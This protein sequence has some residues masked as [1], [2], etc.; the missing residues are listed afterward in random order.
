MTCN[1]VRPGGDIEGKDV[2][3][4]RTNGFHQVARHVWAGDW[5]GWD[6]YDESEHQEILQG[7]EDIG[8]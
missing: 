5:P 8:S 2:Y 1:F 6:G 3:W 4:C 7:C